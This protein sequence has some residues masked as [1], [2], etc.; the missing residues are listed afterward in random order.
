MASA[1]EDGSFQWVPATNTVYFREATERLLYCRTV[2]PADFVLWTTQDLDT[3][4]SPSLPLSLPPFFP[5]Y[6]RLYT[7]DCTRCVVMRAI[8]GLVA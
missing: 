4:L 6:L 1:T 2:L 8:S 7:P 3:P 5:S